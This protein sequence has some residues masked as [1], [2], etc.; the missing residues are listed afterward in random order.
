MVRLMRKLRAMGNRPRVGRQALPFPITPPGVMDHTK[1]APDED[2][3]YDED[4]DDE[5]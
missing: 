2:L 4:E 5:D 1:D 3:M